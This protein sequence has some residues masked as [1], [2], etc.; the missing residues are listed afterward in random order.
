MKAPYIEYD[1][2]AGW[3]SDGGTHY[4]PSGHKTVYQLFSG[5]K[6]W[7][8]GECGYSGI[9]PEVGRPESPAKMLADGRIDE[10][11]AAMKIE[12]EKRK[13]RGS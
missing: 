7:W 2:Y 1:D 6:E 11:K 13:A 12:L 3:F 8:C 4:C 10:F 9:Y 5:G